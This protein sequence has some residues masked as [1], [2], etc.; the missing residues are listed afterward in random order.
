MAP[1]KISP[2]GDGIFDSFMPRA[3]MDGSMDFELTILDGENKI[4][5]TTQAT[6]P[7]TGTLPDGTMAELNKEYM[8]IAIV[9]DRNGFEK[10]YSGSFE[11]T[12]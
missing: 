11:I 5:T 2:N 10:Y 6:A 3:L 9:K 12:P 8:W 4:Y 7:W 1:Q